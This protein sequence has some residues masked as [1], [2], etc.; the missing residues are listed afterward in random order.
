VSVITISDRAFKGK[1]QDLSGPEIES[2]ILERF[3]DAEIKREVV[4]DEPEK[5]AAAFDKHLSAD[6][7]FTTGGTG[8]SPRDC[9]PETTQSYC[10]R[11]LPG[12]AEILRAESYAETPFAILSRGYAGLK[13]NTIIVNFPGSLKAVRLCTRIML[14]VMEHGIQMLRGEGHDE[15]G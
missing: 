11:A 8:I 13:A 9:T 2:L 1:Y 14:P 7:I 3:P 4:P 5:I 12:I 15:H 10:D 6:Y